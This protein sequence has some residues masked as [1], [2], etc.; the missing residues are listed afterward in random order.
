MLSLMHSKQEHSI[1]GSESSVLDGRH[2]SVGPGTKISHVLNGVD[3]EYDYGDG[4]MV[5]DTDVTTE[6]GIKPDPDAQ[7]EEV[8]HALGVMQVGKGASYFR[9]ETHINTILQEVCLIDVTVELIPKDCVDI[10]DQG[11]LPANEG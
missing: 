1:S 3:D 6:N 11:L 10:R 2:P 7:V 5:T 4:A 9:G 8:R